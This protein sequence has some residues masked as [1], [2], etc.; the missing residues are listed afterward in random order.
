MKNEQKNKYSLIL[1]IGKIIYVLDCPTLLSI[2][3]N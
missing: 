1:E 2:V 3:L